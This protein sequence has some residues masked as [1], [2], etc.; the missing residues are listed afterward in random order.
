MD[1]PLF[2]CCSLASV[3]SPSPSTEAGVNV[4]KLILDSRSS[5]NN[6]VGAFLVTTG[7]TAVP[8]DDVRSI[9]NASKGGFGVA[10]ANAAA[11]RG[12]P[13]I[14]LC[15]E[16]AKL[17][18][19][20]HPNIT[21]VIFET[22]DEYVQ[23]LTWIAERWAIAYAV[24]AAAVSDF[25]VEAVTGKMDSSNPPSLPL[26][27]LPK[28]LATWRQLFGIDC[29]IT[30]F[31]LHA[32]PKVGTKLE[33]KNARGALLAA[34]DKQIKECH[35]NLTCANFAPWN[36]N[37]DTA[38]GKKRLWLRRPD[39]G[40][41]EMVG[42]NQQV[43]T[44]LV[45]YIL[46]QANVTWGHSQYLDNDLEHFRTGFEESFFL[47][48]KI[49]TL[50]QNTNLLASTAGSITVP[51]T[52]HALW[53]TPRGAHKPTIG[54]NDLCCVSVT[55]GQD[56]TLAYTSPNPN[57]KA[58]IDSRVYAIVNRFSPFAAAVHF[59]DGWVLKPHVSTKKDFPCGTNKA[60]GEIIAALAGIDVRITGSVMVELT[61]H[62]HTLFFPSPEKIGELE[63]NWQEMR[64][65]YEQHLQEIGKGDSI[66]QLILTPIFHRSC[67]VGIAAKHTKE[68][69]YSFFLKEGCRNGGLGA[70]L[71][72]LINEREVNVGVHSNCQVEQW[73]VDRGFQVLE[74]RVDEGLTILGPPSLRDD[75]VE[76]ATMVIYCPNEGG[77]ILLGK[78]TAGTFQGY[79]ANLGGKVECS[80]G[81]HPEDINFWLQA[82]REVREECGVDLSIMPRPSRSTVL[83][84]RTVREDGTEVV[85]R[86]TCFIVKVP[87]QF[88]VSTATSEHS[89][90]SWHPLNTLQNLPRAQA[91]K[92][93][94][95]NLL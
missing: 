9:S 33:Q 64:R 83:Y 1:I 11:E 84:T 45:D 47:A 91:T 5:V 67:I 35:L 3:D 41:I 36:K 6:K 25:G 2:F 37:P 63:T 34:A 87:T 42:T 85:F 71:V 86:V 46:N 7:G 40:G 38:N 80:P 23:Q 30:G 10:I 89:E 68:G 72:T 29:Y 18:Y 59:H 56:T 62:G 76:A 8:V 31:K 21:I 19:W 75:V 54:A 78:R 43:A 93:S 74:R 15:T 90:I 26:A 16:F 94:H 4:Q 95:H 51:A 79:Y 50:A 60:A 66:S 88:A 13:T 70:A 55:A 39:G 49:L 12:I 52:P 48:G 58:S 92:A 28:V 73:Y 82:C 77:S 69:W 32:S 81:T 27:P 57:I 17:K 44:A 24:S 22:Y 65:L 20:V 61:G 53:A 14:L